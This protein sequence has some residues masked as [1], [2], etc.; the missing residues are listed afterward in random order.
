MIHSLALLALTL[1]PFVSG[2]TS[3]SGTPNPSDVSVGSAGPSAPAT[4]SIGST[5]TDTVPT[6]MSTFMSMPM[7]MSMSGV[8]S[9]PSAGLTP[10]ST[11]NCTF[12]LETL[13]NSTIRTTQNITIASN[14]K[15]VDVNLTSEVAYTGCWEASANVG[16]TNGTMGMRTETPGYFQMSFDCE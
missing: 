1:S 3:T 2:Q 10:S 11:P 8:S 13:A 16:C 15:T 9:Q 5:V 4:S 7:S 6:G 14:V 12:S